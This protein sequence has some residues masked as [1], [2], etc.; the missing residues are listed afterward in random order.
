MAASGRGDGGAGH[1]TMDRGKHADDEKGEDDDEAAGRRGCGWGRGHRE[2]RYHGTPDFFSQNL[3]GTHTIHQP[4]KVTLY[5]PTAAIARQ[6]P[7]CSVATL[8]DP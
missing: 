2:Q 7:W 8:N 1:A 4:D 6:S 3:R 5:E